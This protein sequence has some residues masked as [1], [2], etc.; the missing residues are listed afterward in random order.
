MDTLSEEIDIISSS[1]RIYD[2]SVLFLVFFVWRECIEFK[3][4]HF[5]NLLT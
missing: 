5:G 4:T 1:L 2:L 3:Q